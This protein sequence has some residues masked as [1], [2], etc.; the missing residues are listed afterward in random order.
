VFDG[1]DL[2]PGRVVA[3]IGGADGS[4][5]V[6]LIAG[7]PERIGVVFDLPAVAPA[8]MSSL[9]ERGLGDR[10]TF[11]S[12]DFFESVP[13]A[14]VYVLSFIL[15]DWD[16]ESAVRI[17]ETVRKASNA[18]ARLL[19]LEGVVPPGDTPHLMKIVDLTMLGMLPGR[20]R[21]EPEFRVLLERSGFTLDRIVPTSTAFSIIE[22]SAN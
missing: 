3:D 14:D 15:H 17:L 21:T 18:G 2:P 4:V 8:A 7:L 9:A 11:V 20:E 1:Y 5:L 16:D 13:A 22:A 10:I 19:V 6:Q 12:G